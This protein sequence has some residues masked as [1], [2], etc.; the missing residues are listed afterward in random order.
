MN[1]VSLGSSLQLGKS[2][3]QWGILRQLDFVVLLMTS[4]RLCTD[5]IVEG[6][7]SK[8]ATVVGLGGMGPGKVQEMERGVILKEV[9][10]QSLDMLSEGGGIR[11][12]KSFESYC[13]DGTANYQNKALKCFLPLH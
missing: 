4:V 6:N 11:C 10:I 2:H 13:H 9:V 3:F 1:E 12:A 8:T 7:G 5:A